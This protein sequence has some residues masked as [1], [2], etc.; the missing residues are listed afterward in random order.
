MP[1]G[2]PHA[3]R[4]H[5][6][7]QILAA[8]RD[9]LLAHGP[10][11]VTTAAIS[12]RSGAPTGSLYH[13]FGSR[14]VMVAELWIR[15]IRRFHADLFEATSAA[16]PGLPRALAAALA[17]VDFATQ[18]PED[19]RLLLVASRADLDA[20]ASLPA[21]LAEALRTLNDPVTALLKQVTT[22]LYGSVTRDGVDR[23]TIGTISLPYTVVRHRL[24][25]DG[26]PADLRH[27]VETAARAVLTAP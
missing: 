2:R 6:D 16:E 20:D 4:T 17:V 25:Q 10:R 5:S 9:L 14:S 23:V 21:E 3:R 15:T 8:V 22:E 11:G 7:E 19:A 13:R 12:Q 27:L 1:T 18:H 26:D 24:L